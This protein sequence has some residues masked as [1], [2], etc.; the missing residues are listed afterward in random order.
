MNGYNGSQLRCHI[1]R[2]ALS[3]GAEPESLG[4]MAKAFDGENARRV[5]SL[6]P[7]PVVLDTRRALAPAAPKSHGDVWVPEHMRGGKVVRG[8]FRRRR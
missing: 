6:A 2:E 1:G 4:F 3:L 5:T 8:H 7:A